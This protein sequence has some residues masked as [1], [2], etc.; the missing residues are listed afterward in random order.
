MFNDSSNPSNR[1]TNG[2]YELAFDYIIEEVMIV[3][4]MISVSINIAVLFHLRHKDQ[5]FKFLLAEALVDFAYLFIVAFAIFVYCGSPCNPDSLLAKLYIIVWENYFTSC[6]AIYSILSEIFLSLQRLFIISSKSCFV[7]V[8]FVKTS[9][10]LACIALIFYSP[11]LFLNRL[12]YIEPNKYKIVPLFHNRL[13]SI[14]DT[15]L[16]STRLVLATFGLFSINLITLIQFKKRIETKSKLLNNLNRKFHNIF[17][18]SR[19]QSD[20]KSFIPRLL[21]NK[22]LD[23]CVRYSI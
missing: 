2:S 5:T 20:L 18:Y 8:S 17:A 6:L 23:P 15:I 11:M 10:T 22:Y 3:L 19:F 14:I 4:A 1:T 7:N 21:S 16:S 13:I 9:A 12:D